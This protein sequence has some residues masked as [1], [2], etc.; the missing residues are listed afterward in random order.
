MDNIL[1]YIFLSFLV[2]MISVNSF[3][4]K[5]YGQ[6]DSTIAIREVNEWLTRIDSIDEDSLKLL[7]YNH[8]VS[9]YGYSLPYKTMEIS[10]DAI[11][12]SEELKDTSLKSIF[13]LKIGGNLRNLGLYDSAYTLFK[14]VKELCDQNGDVK[15]KGMALTSL[16]QVLFTMSDY[17]TAMKYCLEGLAIADNH[18]DTVNLINALNTMAV[19]HYSQGNIDKALGEFE[20]CLRYSKAQKDTINI[21]TLNNN[22]GAIY[23]E[24]GQ[25]KRALSFFMKAMEFGHYNH[26]KPMINA[27]ECYVK[28]KEYDKAEVL[29]KEVIKL[30]LK[31]LSINKVLLYHILGELYNEKGDYKES[32]KMLHLSM[33]RALKIGFVNSILD[34]HSTFSKTYSKM[35]DY[36]LAYF[37]QKKYQ[38][39]KDSVFSNSYK[40][41]I[42]ELEEK[43]QSERK[44]SRIEQ[45]QKETEISDYQLEKERTKMTVLWIGLILIT[46]GLFII[47]YFYNQKRRLNLAMER[48]KE[49]VED[50]NAKL[51][52]S[53][54][55]KN[56]LLKEVHHRVKN[57]LQIISS[58]MSLQSVN[59][60]DNPEVLKALNDARARIESMSLIHQHLYQTENLKEID[61]NDYFSELSIYLETL[62][63]TNK[64]VQV[65][66]ETNA[67]KLNID[68]IIPVG[69]IVNELIT[70]S[71]KYAFTNVDKAIINIDL[72]K[73]EEDGQ[74][75][76]IFTDNG[77]GMPKEFDYKDSPS[78]GIKLV[79]LLSKKLK[80]E[81]DFTNNDGLCFSMIFQ[82]INE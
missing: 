65:T 62:I 55:E 49:V 1:N 13:L 33:D 31:D 27:G 46:T 78:L 52:I 58:L 32:I 20:I 50:Q 74:Y 41:T 19:I 75:L 7:E 72:E 73:R 3:S 40:E 70:N 37:H 5:S 30:N 39:L 11:R 68:T 22:I 24:K 14:Q 2:F 56:T 45:L 80:G 44:Q 76:L 48:Q 51:Q 10:W 77:K 69:I 54:I 29:L 60:Q 71:I 23:K 21:E 15:I 36:K 81:I 12:L 64:K 6:M 16:G 53:I 43:Y 38:E 34:V 66:I 35:G 25:Y 9:R 17:K 18:S 8:L 42:A 67:I 79:N 63:Q 28:L 59:I 61:C 4:I 57:N 26:A 47:F 82:I